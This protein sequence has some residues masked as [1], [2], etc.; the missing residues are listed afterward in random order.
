MIVYIKNNTFKRKI[1]FIIV[2]VYLFINE[3][4]LTSKLLQL[5]MR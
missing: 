1:Q 4:Q 2:L 5:L 3:Y